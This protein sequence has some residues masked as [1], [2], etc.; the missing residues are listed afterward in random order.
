MRIEDD[1][2]VTTEGMELMTDI[3]R[4]VLEIEALMAEGRDLPEQFP[5]QTDSRLER[6]DSEGPFPCQ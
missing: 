4:T 1:I 3:P 2:V 6:S 5:L